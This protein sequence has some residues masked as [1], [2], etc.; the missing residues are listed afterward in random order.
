ME[1]DDP[2]AKLLNQRNVVADEEIGQLPFLLQLLQKLDDLLLHGHVQCG[3]GLVKDE[4]VRVVHQCS[5]DGRALAL[6]AGD[7]MRIAREKRSGKAAAFQQRA[8]LCLAFGLR[9]ALVA[10]A[11]ADAVAQCAARIEGVGR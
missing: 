11:L 6:A 10:Q 5:C 1:H 7:L 2:V 3:G 4:D 9:H 8:C